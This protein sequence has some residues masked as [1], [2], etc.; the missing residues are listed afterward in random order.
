MCKKNCFIRFIILIFLNKISCQHV[1]NS[2]L[3]LVKTSKLFKTIQI[4]DVVGY[5]YCNSEFPEFKGNIELKSITIIDDEEF[6]CHQ[7]GIKV[8]YESLSPCKD[9]LGDYVGYITP[10]KGCILKK[11]AFGS[12]CPRIKQ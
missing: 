5:F 4:N 11:Q 6:D 1:V 8:T 12:T 2:N 9:I 7:I 3:D 10:E